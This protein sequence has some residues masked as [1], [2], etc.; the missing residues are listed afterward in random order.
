MPWSLARKREAWA[1]HRTLNRRRLRDRA[2]ERRARIKLELFTKLGG[3]CVDCG[4]GRVT[5]LHVDH[6]DSSRKQRPAGHHTYLAL[7]K[8][9]GKVKIELRCANCNLK[10]ARERGEGP[11]LRHIELKRLAI[12]AYGGGC[13]RCGESD[14]DVLCFDHIN[15]GGTE[16]RR[17]GSHS[18]GGGYT[19]MRVL[20][21]SRPK[22]R[23][24]L[25][26]N[27]NYDIHFGDVAKVAAQG[28]RAP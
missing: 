28:R 17:T 10:K 18:H 12:A 13:D 9:L 8:Q 20:V 1:E 14:E 5:S 3:K 19:M 15:G 11:G 24:L 26:A 27:C 25:C 2:R 4:H 6:I 21:T 22:D 7:L 16:L 23:R